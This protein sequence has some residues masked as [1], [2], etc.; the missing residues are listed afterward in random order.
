MINIVLDDGTETM[1]A[2]LFH[3]TLPKLGLSELENADLL[4][5]QKQNILGKEMVFSGNVRMN[6]FFNN[7][8]FIINDLQ[9]INL[10]ELFASLD[11]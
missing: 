10:D 11:K 2:V 3:D 9:E 7:P 6:N 1:R 8:E 5:Q 4:L